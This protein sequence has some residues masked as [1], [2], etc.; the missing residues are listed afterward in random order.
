[1]SRSDR[2]QAFTIESVAATLLLVGTVIFLTQSAVVGPLTTSTSSQQLTE[3]Q[4]GVAAGMLDAAVADGLVVPTLVYWDDLNETFHGAPDEGYYVGRAPSTAFGA[5]LNE[6]FDEREVAYNVNV[7]SVDET[8]EPRRRPLVEQGSP[9]DDAVQV[10]RLVTL[11]D[12]DVLRDRTGAATN[13]T[14]ASVA[15]DFYLSDTQPGSAVYNVVRVE[16]TVWPV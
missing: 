15:D 3:Q 5:L 1:M 9:S 10:S 12:D 4:R 7:Y 6:T 14:L 13:V 8:G 11:Y 16:V 2:A